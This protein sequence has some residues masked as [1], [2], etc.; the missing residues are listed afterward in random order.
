M[1]HEI[2]PENLKALL[3]NWSRGLQSMAQEMNSL[4]AL[5]GDGDLGTT[6]ARCGV[7]MEE[8]LPSMPDTLEGIF[9]VLAQSCA[10]ASG[11]SFGTLLAVGFLSAAK[12]V[13]ERSTM[14]RELMASILQAVVDALSSRGGAKLGDKT[15]LD[16][17]EAI[18]NVLAEGKRQ[19][20]LQKLACDAAMDALDLLRNKPNRIGRASMFSE[21]SVGMDDP[22]MV[23]VW[24]MTQ[25]LAV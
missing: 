14:N 23:A 24:R 13:G 22:G 8:A 5:L 17:L 19:S 12:S 20:D 3:P 25:N 1:P 4:D 21:R 6:L 11:S 9:K 18:R 7:N 15:M 2:S 16:S 10:K